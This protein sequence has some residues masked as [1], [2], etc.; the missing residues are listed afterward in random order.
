[1]LS[2]SLMVV[3]LALAGAAVGVVLHALLTKGDSLLS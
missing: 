2:R 1:M 3:A